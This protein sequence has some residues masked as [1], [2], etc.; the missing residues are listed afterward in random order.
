MRDGVVF[1]H[2]HAYPVY[3]ARYRENRECVRRFLSD[4]DNLQTI[5]RNGLHRTTT[6]T[7]PW[8]GLVAA[9]SILGVRTDLWVDSEWS[10]DESAAAPYA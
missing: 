10:S 3:N 7:I 9:D 1:R 8:T 2:G 6:W 5:G 4:F